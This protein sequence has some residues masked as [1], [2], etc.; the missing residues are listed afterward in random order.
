ML[1]SVSEISQ[2]TFD[3]MGGRPRLSRNLPYLSVLI[4]RPDKDGRLS[5][6]G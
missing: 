5:W 1:I 3:V 6:S 4:Y 2:H